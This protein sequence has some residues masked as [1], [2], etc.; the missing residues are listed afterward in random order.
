VRYE[1][2]SAGY[3]FIMN[4]EIESGNWAGSERVGL[5]CFDFKKE[6]GLVVH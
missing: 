3:E 6:N 4:L 5:V 2:Y 1:F